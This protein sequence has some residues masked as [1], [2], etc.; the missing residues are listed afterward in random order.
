MK[1]KKVYNGFLAYM[2]W[3]GIMGTLGT[4]VPVI[5][6]FFIKDF[7]GSSSTESTQEETAL[8]IGA[9]VIILLGCISFIVIP[10]LWVKKRSPEGYFWQNWFSCLWSG[11][12]IGFKI[13]LCFMIIFIPLA[14]RISTGHTY[15]GYD[16]NGTEIYLKKVG[17]HTFTDMSGNI[18][19]DR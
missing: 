14:I 9:L 4:L 19:T 18:Y 1:I 10:T 2:L 6:S 13:T 7:W 16:A 8:N 3:A 12:K 11:I 5:M 15:T 17:D